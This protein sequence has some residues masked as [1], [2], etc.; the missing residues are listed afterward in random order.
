MFGID[1]IIKKDPDV[2][3]TVRNAAD[4]QVALSGAPGTLRV[5]DE[6]T[7]YLRMPPTYMEPETCLMVLRN[8][9]RGAEERRRTGG[10]GA[11]AAVTAPQPVTAP[12][13]KPS[14]P[15]PPLAASRTTPVPAPAPAKQVAK[16]N[17]QPKPAPPPPPKPVPSA[18][19][20]AAKPQPP[21]SRELENLVALRD[22]GILTD[23]EFEKAKGRLMAKK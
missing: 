10:D 5:I 1:S 3:L 7:I 12:E 19:S 6:K 23:E 21:R 20:P 18:T 11:A 9:V 2:V 22:S 4:A 16:S 13:V 15:K 14:Q 8:L 17:G